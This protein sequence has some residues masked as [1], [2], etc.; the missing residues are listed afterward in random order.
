VANV[1]TLGEACGVGRG[2]GLGWIEVE[3]EMLRR[4]DTEVEAVVLDL[5][6]TEVLC[7]EG[8]REYGAGSDPDESGCELR[9]PNPGDG[10]GR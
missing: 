2:D 4:E 7:G 3:L 6:T 8:G 9:Q 10:H 1:P 5:V